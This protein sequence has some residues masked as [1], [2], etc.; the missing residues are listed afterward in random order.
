MTNRNGL[1]V[2]RLAAEFVVIVLGVLGALAADQW[3]QD[4]ENRALEREYL[5][6]LMDDVRYDRGEIEFVRALS[7]AGLQ[8]LDSLRSPGFAERASDLQL[9]AT[10]L[11]ASN[12]REVDLSRGTFEELI[13]SGRIA[14]IT[15]PEVR[16]ALSE[17][18]RFVREIAGFR[19]YV[20]NDFRVWAWERVP[21]S[22]LGSFQTLCRSE[23]GPD[24]T[25][26][27][28]ERATTQCEFDLPPAGADE[29]RSELTTDDARHLM[30]RQTILFGATVEI[31][32]TL[33]ARLA[34]L[35]AVLDPA[36]P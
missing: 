29:L 10:T 36:T 13:A 31:T 9:V 3:V 18:D 21:S 28:V 20:D 16:A 17:Y 7:M 8:A 26:T 30:R 23:E 6:R 1:P 12:D 24:T 15:D 32:G 19:D 11:I 27:Y 35:Q 14:L 2:G 33:L 22:S 5:E 4:R 34:A 25:G